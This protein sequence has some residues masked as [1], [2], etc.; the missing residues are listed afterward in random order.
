MTKKPH[1]RRSRQEEKRR[2]IEA[3]ADKFGRIDPDRVWQAARDPKHVLHKEFPWDLETAARQ[4]WRARACELI[5]EIRVIVVIEDRKI[6]APAYVHDPRELLPSAYIKTMR[7][8]K[9]EDLAERNLLEELARI[10]GAVVRA[11]SLA[12][13]FG[14]EGKLERLLDGVIDIRRHFGDRRRGGD[15]TAPPPA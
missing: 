9:D 10:E 14:L 7:V 6:A 15:A 12:A 11:R 5:R 4:R 3:C 1:G 13:I 2:A 8:A